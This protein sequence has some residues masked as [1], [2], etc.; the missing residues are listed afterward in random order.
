M[1]VE[2]NTIRTMLGIAVLA[3]GAGWI[4]HSAISDGGS[5]H[6][7]ADDATGKEIVGSGNV[8][9][10]DRPLDDVHAIRLDGAYKA[11]ITIG[12]K[13]SLRIT[14]DDNVVKLI[15]TETDDGTL[16]VKTRED[17]S[18]KSAP[19]LTITVPQLDSLHLE[20][21]TVTVTG[22]AGDAF[23]LDIDG[24]SDV[25]ASGAVQHASIEIDG[26]GKLRLKDLATADMTLRMDGAGDAEVTATRA[27]DVKIDGAGHVRYFGSP[28]DVKKDVEGF[29]LV[30]SDT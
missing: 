27:L 28:K 26:A 3:A 20:T 19:R 15:E 30:E 2:N 12:G 29:G 1:P 18:L 14:A 23:K 6:G 24:A 4:A 10:V 17:Y 11:K 22:L 13:P 25:T 9:D 8:I 5:H 21:S 16:T 7:L